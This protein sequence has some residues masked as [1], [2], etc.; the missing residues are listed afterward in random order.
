MIELAE[1]ALRVGLKLGATDV[2][3][4]VEREKFNMVRFSN[5]EV[6]LVESDELTELTVYLSKGGRRFLASRPWSI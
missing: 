4:L 1:K 2:G 5:N 6:T 3:V